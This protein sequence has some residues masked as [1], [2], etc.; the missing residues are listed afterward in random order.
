MDMKW[1]DDE[2]LWEDVEQHSLRNFKRKIGS[3]C[4]KCGGTGFIG[5][6]STSYNKQKCDCVK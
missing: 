6:G 5:D 1:N 4:A 2:Q 3:Y